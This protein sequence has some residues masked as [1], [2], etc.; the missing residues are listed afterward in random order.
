MQVAAGAAP[1][2]S[3]AA[4]ERKDSTN[5]TLVRLLE[6]L[7]RP[8][9]FAVRIPST[10]AVSGVAH[11]QRGRRLRAVATCP[12]ACTHHAH[13]GARERVRDGDRGLLEYVE[14]EARELSGEAFSRFMVELY[15]RL[16]LLISKG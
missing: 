10:P 2:A 8:G 16:Q 3:G 12:P 11:V 14:A 5:A 4:K 1:G 7:C 9:V 15:A 6:E 13:A